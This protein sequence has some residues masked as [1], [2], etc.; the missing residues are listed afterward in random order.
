MNRRCSRAARAARGLLISAVLARHST[1]QEAAASFP[2]PVPAEVEVRGVRP[3]RNDSEFKI[4]SAQARQAPGTQGDP[5]KVIEN[6][7]GVSRAPFGSDQLLLW[8]AA[9]E[10]TRVYV[11]GVEI[12]RLFHGSGIRSTVNGDL[13]RSVTVT[14]GAYGADFG[15]AVG[16]LVRLETRDLPGDGA[17]AVLDLSTLDASAL[18]SAPLGERTRV[19]L[20][21]RYGLLQHTLSA[22]GA[23]DVGEF[24]AVPRYGDYQGKAQLALGERELLEAAFLGASDVLSRSAANRDPERVTALDANNRFERVYLRY[25]RSAPDGSRVEVVPW[26]GHDLD[27]SDAHFG[28]KRALLEQSALRWGLRAEQRSLVVPGATLSLGL[29]FAGS[30]THLTR[31]GSL[32]IPAREGDVSVFGQPPGNDGNADQ[33]STTQLDVAPYATLD[34][35]LGPLTLSPGLRCDGYL[36]GASRKTPRVRLTPAIGQSALEVRFEPRLAARLRLGTRVTLF[37][38]AGLYSQPPAAADS[39]AVF[40]SPTLGP[41]SALHASLGE[42]VSVTKTLSAS[43]IGYYRSLSERAV[44]DPSPTPKLANTLVMDGTGR[45]YGVQF[46]L[47]QRPWHGFFGWIA[48]TISRSE[49]RDG[50]GAVVRV[51]D[52]D[53]PHVLTVV[54]S[55]LLG[56]D[57]TVGLRF[58]YASGAPRTPVEGALYDETDNRFQPIFG[59]QN[60]L[61]LPP[62][63]QLD[64]RI[65]RR[66]RLGRA[67]LSVSF[68]VLNVT[69]HANAKELAYSFDYAQRA[70]ITG[71]PLVAVLGARLEL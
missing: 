13:L 52:Y 19:A 6:L 62:F 57:W 9:P 47:R 1:A 5:V 42:S 39:S 41:E 23:R 12:P 4:S 22:V 30:S 43:V 60:S 69:D 18:L 8:G 15:R 16:G 11:D 67:R 14:P 21:G 70:P 61:R 37:G 46:L 49:Q 50:P 53:E 48:Y 27:R 66:F 26:F 17:H 58:R 55:Q 68:E 64:A 2:P 36:L 20:A 56:D 71:L 32:T 3:S 44:R 24:F 35:Q 33:W 29:D 31:E 65:D 7:P 40:G 63:W 45:S 34:W 38:A 51:F 59:A 25:L 28:S 10:D 54:A